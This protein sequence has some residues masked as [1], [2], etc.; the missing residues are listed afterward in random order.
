LALKTPLKYIPLWI[1]TLPIGWLINS[2]GNMYFPKSFYYE[3]IKK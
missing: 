3:F 1:I 2:V